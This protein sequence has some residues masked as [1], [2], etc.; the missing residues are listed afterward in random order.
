[1]LKNREKVASRFA[2]LGLKYMFVG[3]SHIQ[4]TDQFTSKNGNIITEVNVGSLCGYPAPIVDVEINNNGTLTYNVN[5]FENI[6]FQWQRNRCP[7]VSGRACSRFDK[8][9]FLN[10]Y[11]RRF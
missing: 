9:N 3:H 5:Q 11:E 4:A 10:P 8:Q 7:A 6:Q 2:D 1:M